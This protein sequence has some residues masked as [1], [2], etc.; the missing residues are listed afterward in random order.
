M[1]PHRDKISTFNTFKKLCE[2]FDQRSLL[3]TISG[4]TCCSGALSGRSSLQD[5][6]VG[7]QKGECA[8]SA[9]RREQNPRPT[10][11]GAHS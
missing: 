5:G 9:A 6:H 7:V 2:G 1:F 11:C 10:L 8:A 3:E 4:A